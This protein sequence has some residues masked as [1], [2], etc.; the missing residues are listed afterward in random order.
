MYYA[1]TSSRWTR[2]LRDVK[3]CVSR[4]GAQNAKNAAIRDLERAYGHTDG[5]YR[6]PPY[7]ESSED[8]VDEVKLEEV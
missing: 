1:E 2:A 8:D 6:R 5:P 4:G 3:V 7:S